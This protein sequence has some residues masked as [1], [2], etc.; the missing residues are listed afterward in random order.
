MPKPIPVLTSY[1]DIENEEDM[2]RF[3]FRAYRQAAGWSVKAVDAKIGVKGFT[4]R[5]EKPGG[6]YRFDYIWRMIFELG[7]D[8]GFLFRGKTGNVKSHIAR[9]VEAILKVGRTI[10]DD[11]VIAVLEAAGLDPIEAL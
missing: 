4:S 11:E 9:R 8:E 10:Q 6:L 3:R 7:I 2:L 1:K 5:F